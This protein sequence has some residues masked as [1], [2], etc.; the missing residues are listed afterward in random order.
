M[1]A[2][3]NVRQSVLTNREPAML[4]H[5]HWVF[6]PFIDVEVLTYFAIV[7]FFGVCFIVADCARI[8]LKIRREDK[9]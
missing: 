5:P 1:P 7:G 4:N 8:Y 6:G 3:Y 9:Q 2:Y